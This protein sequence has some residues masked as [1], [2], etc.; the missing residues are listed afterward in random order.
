MIGRTRWQFRSVDSTQDIAFRLAGQ[1]AKSGT[2][3][4]ADYQSSGRGRHGRTWD[5][6]ANTALMFSLL[7]RPDVPVHLLGSL[8]IH[9]ANVLY[10]V[11]ALFGADNVTLKWPNDVLIHGRKVSGILVQTRM[12]PDLVAVIGIG[13]NISTPSAALPPTAISLTDAICREVDADALLEEILF[14]LDAMWSTW[15]PEFTPEQIQAIDH[16]LWLCGEQA[17]LLDADRETIGIIAGIAADSA[18]RLQVGGEEH[19]I[20]AG[21]ITRGPRPIVP[22]VDA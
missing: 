16:R 3:V 11:F 18:L 8:S 21:E 6:P 19:R 17:S 15:Q 7:L 12:Q 13:I 1:G 20:H 9:I 4:R 14:R 2:I 22:V 10:D 5:V